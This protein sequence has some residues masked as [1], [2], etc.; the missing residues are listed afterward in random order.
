MDFQIF[1][2]PFW[3]FTQ[4]KSSEFMIP[5]FHDYSSENHKI[6]DLLCYNFGY[7]LCEEGSFLRKYCIIYCNYLHRLFC[8]YSTP[9]PMVSKAVTEED[10]RQT[11]TTQDHIAERYDI[12]RMWKSVRSLIS[13]EFFFVFIFV[14]LFLKNDIS[15][16]SYFD[17]KVLKCDYAKLALSW[18][19]NL[20][21]SNQF[22]YKR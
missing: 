1:F 5:A 8:P 4:K 19:M 12:F 7:I 13:L 20:W 15:P 3:G 18:K 22:E 9:T 16:F 14:Y 21:Y 17:F 2:G 10:G 11:A 6:R